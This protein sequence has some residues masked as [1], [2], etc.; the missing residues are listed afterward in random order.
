M[1]SKF[2]QYTHHTSTH[3]LLRRFGKYPSSR[4]R[5]NR[6]HCSFNIKV[7]WRLIIAYLWSPNPSMLILNNVK[8]SLQSRAYGS[9]QVLPITEVNIDQD[10]L[11]AQ[12]TIPATKSTVKHWYIDDWS[13]RITHSPIVFLEL[14]G[15]YRLHP[16]T[17]WMV[18][19]LVNYSCW[20]MHR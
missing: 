7:Q 4:N 1:L 6:Y 16:S 3:T 11:Q 9:L 10:H 20:E 18:P 5:A 15:V 8:V 13:Q 14:C 12:A 2:C 17:I 19:H